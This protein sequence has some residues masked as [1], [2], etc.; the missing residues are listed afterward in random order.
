MKK[1]EGKN[2][3]ISC[4]K[5][6]KKLCII[7]LIFFSLY[8]IILIIEV[9][10]K[11]LQNSYLDNENIL[12]LP[13]YLFFLNLGEFL[14]IIPNIFLKRKTSSQNDNK[15]SSK[16][17][18]NNMLEYIFNP[19]SINFSKK[20]IIYLSLFIIL[21]LFKDLLQFFY[22]FLDDKYYYLIDF[23]YSFQFELFFLFVLAKYMNNVKFYKHQYFSII[24][25]SMIG[26]AKLIIKNVEEEIG[27]FFFLLIGGIILSFL[28]SLIIVYIKGLIEKKIF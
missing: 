6:N 10:F 21:K 28:K 7:V 14:M 17:E 20:E 24:I 9:I 2:R 13:S 18:N 1:N 12:N 4:G 16:H 5:F 15:P 19:S 22:I 27:K 11:Y 25:L 3:F 26:L 8:I 23:N